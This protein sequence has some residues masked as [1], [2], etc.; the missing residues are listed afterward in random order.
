M[1]PPGPN[2]L[3]FSIINQENFLNQLGQYVLSRCSHNI[4]GGDELYLKYCKWKLVLLL[5][6]K[7]LPISRQSSSLHSLQ[8]QICGD[9]PNHC[10]NDLTFSRLTHPI[11]KLPH[12][13][14]PHLRQ[15]PPTPVAHDTFSPRW[16]TSTPPHYFQWSSC[17]IWKKEQER[18]S[19][20]FLR[21][22]LWLCTCYVQRTVVCD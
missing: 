9:S 13:F 6:V 21:E 5:K 11:P 12:D 8:V 22:I 10:P 19:G 16:T 4:P 2:Q 20:I 14:Y 18:S 15:P 3:N 7:H 1:T 17:E